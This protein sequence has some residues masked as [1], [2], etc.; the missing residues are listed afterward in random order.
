MRTA[1]ATR[2]SRIRS[3]PAISCSLVFFAHPLTV[4]YP[5]VEQPRCLPQ[6]RREVA[7]ADAHGVVLGRR[8]QVLAYR[9]L[10]AGRRVDPAQRLVPRSGRVLDCV[11]DLEHVS[12]VVPPFRRLV[13]QRDLQLAAGRSVLVHRLVSHPASRRRCCCFHGCAVLAC[14]LTCSWSTSPEVCSADICPLAG[15][16]ARCTTSAVSCSA[17]AAA[18]VARPSSLVSPAS[19]RPSIAS[20]CRP[21]CSAYRAAC[22]IPDPGLWSS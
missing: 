5:A 14:S 2:E 17:A 7:R 16:Y 15:S 8:Q 20:R 10:R 9:F 6:V 18:I 21:L 4:P 3:R 19:P 22:G 12:V 1:T 11:L 13:S